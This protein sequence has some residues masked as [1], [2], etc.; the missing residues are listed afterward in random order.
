M[1]GHRLS[2]ED[3]ERLRVVFIEW[4]NAMLMEVVW[5]IENLIRDR[6]KCLTMRERYVTKGVQRRIR[7]IMSTMIFDL[8]NCFKG[9]GC[10]L[11]VGQ[12]WSGSYGVG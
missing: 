4:D 12:S 2:E 6:R 10:C 1:V 3:Q 8:K 7:H 11:D 5:L 9:G